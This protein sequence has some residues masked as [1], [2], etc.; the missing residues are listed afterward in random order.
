MAVRNWSL[1]VFVWM[2]TRVVAGEL[3][4]MRDRSGH[5]ARISV[6]LLQRVS[7]SEW[8]VLLRPAKR[9]RTGD[10]TSRSQHPRLDRVLRSQR[11]PQ[12]CK[13]VVARP[14]RGESACAVA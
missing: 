13:T 3:S 5:A 8:R 4:G 2:L 6:N 1:I 7:D 11:G 12:H 9:V 14:P 10:R